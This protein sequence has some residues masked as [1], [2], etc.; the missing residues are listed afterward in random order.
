MVANH[1]KSGVKMFTQ[2]G[3]C[4]WCKKHAQVKKLSYIDG[5]TNFACKAC[6]ETAKMDV[7]LYNLEQAT[8]IA[9]V[10]AQNTHQQSA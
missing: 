4:D 9:Q 8:F 6:Y 10:Q 7:Q 3:V 2:D 1:S 5:N